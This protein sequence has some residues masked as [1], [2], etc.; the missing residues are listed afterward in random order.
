MRDR[1]A[2]WQEL[3]ALPFW[4]RSFPASGGAAF[5]ERWRLGTFEAKRTGAV[6]MRAEVR[7]QHMD[8]AFVDLTLP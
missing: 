2:L 3:S 4:E 5:D 6:F 1:E 7:R 8:T